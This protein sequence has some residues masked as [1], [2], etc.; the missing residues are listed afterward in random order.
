M[1][2]INV[3]TIN[4]VNNYTKNYFNVI[5]SNRKLLLEMNFTLHFKFQSDLTSAI[6]WQQYAEV[7]THN[8]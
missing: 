6:G 2:M 4:N 7:K 5:Y 1:P 3:M 8:T